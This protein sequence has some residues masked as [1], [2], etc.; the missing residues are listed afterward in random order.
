MSI[1]A[2]PGLATVFSSEKFY[3]N[4]KVSYQAHATTIYSVDQ[5]IEILDYIGAKVDSE[6]IL[7]FALTLVEVGELINIAEDNGEFAA[8]EAL[9][10]C[11]ENLEGFNALLCV[12]RKVDGCYVSDI[13]QPLKLKTI[14]DCAIAAVTLLFTHLVSPPEI[15]KTARGR[16]NIDFDL[17]G[18]IPPPVPATTV[19]IA[20][21]LKKNNNGGGGGGKPSAPLPITLRAEL[22]QDD[23]DRLDKI[24]ADLLTTLAK[25]RDDLA[26][27]RGQLKQ[28]TKLLEENLPHF[29]KGN[30]TTKFKDIEVFHPLLNE[31]T[32]KLANKIVAKL[33]VKHVSALI[34]FLSL[35][36]S[37][38]KS[39]INSN[40]MLKPLKRGE[41]DPTRPTTPTVHVEPAKVVVREAPVRTVLKS[42]P[43]DPSRALEE[44]LLEEERTQKIE[45][46]AVAS[47]AAGGKHIKLKKGRHALPDYP[48]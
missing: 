47:A 43:Y 25:G 41:R 8:G 10:A 46:E 36:Q 18:S 24:H 11:L 7:P 13:V 44:F 39:K 35:V 29:T 22:P 28:L 48:T 21:K 31:P 3:V 12:S 37:K 33:Q 45:E 42:T 38:F 19:P 34:S 40:A 5:A 1:S 17:T 30:V 6:D 16:I 14:R 9:A 26:N 4:A 15:S 20:S 2:V 32:N 23:K 27:E